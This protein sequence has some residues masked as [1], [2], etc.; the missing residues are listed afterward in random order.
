MWPNAAESINLFALS[1]HQ[2]LT[3]KSLKEM[4]FVY[5]R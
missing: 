5:P 4:V 1:I 2:Q 3:V